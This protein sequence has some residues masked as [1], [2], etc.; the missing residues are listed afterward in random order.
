MIDLIKNHEISLVVMSVAEH[1]GE[2]DD[3]GAIRRT[4]LAE[5]VTY[6]TTMAGG[7]AAAEGIRAGR[8]GRRLRPP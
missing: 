2:L 1:E 4:C 5:Q 6:H 7:L 3:A 8:K